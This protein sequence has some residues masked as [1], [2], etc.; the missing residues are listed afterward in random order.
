MT[1][2]MTDAPAAPA[3]SIPT[4]PAT[5]SPQPASRPLLR[6]SLLSVAIVVFG[7][8]LLG[9]VDLHSSPIG[10]VQLS[11][12]AIAIAAVAG[13]LMVFNIE[14]RREVYTFTF[15]EM[16]LLIGLFL[17]APADLV[18]GRL[19]G[20]AAFLVVHEHQQLRKLT[21][22]LASFF[23]E[24][25]VLLVVFQQLGQPRDPDRP[26]TWAAAIVA[27]CAA[28]LLGFI[29]VAKAVRWHGGPL[30]LRSILAIG[31]V[32]APVNTSLAL[33]AV[34]LLDRQPW[35]VLLLAGLA[36]FVL[37]AYRSYTA[38]RQ[39]HESLS[40]LYDFTRM[41]SGAQKPDD[42]L[43]AIL[44]QAKDLLRA[45]RAEIWLA[46]DR[47]GHLGLAVNDD[48]PSFC[49]LPDDVGAR[50]ERWFTAGRGTTVITS[51]SSDLQLRA[52]AR[53][54]GADDCIVAPVTEAGRVVGLFA[55]VNRLGELNG[56]RPEEGPM[57]ATLAN[58]ASVALENGRLIARLRQQSR[59]H[60][61]DSRH[62]SLTR[63]PN[64]ALFNQRLSAEIERYADATTSPGGAV[65][66][67]LMD[68]DGFKEINDT[69]GHQFGD[70]ALIEVAARIRDVLRNDWLVARLGGDEFALLAPGL[71]RRSDLD[72]V[73]RRIRR[74][75]A[76]PIDVDGVRVTTGI[77]IGLA[78]Y[79]DDGVDAATVLQRADVAMYGAKAGLG[80]GVHFYDATSDTN[81]PRRLKLANDLRS[82]IADHQLSLVFQPKVRL[83]D[84]GLLGVEALVRWTHPELGAISPE[85]FIP[86]AER[87]GA[88]VAITE[89]VLDQSMRQ[90]SRWHREGK[91]W[92]V[93]VNLSMRNLLDPELVPLVQRLLRTSDL[94]P[95]FLTLEIT[96]TN[97]MAD[98]SRTIAVLA[99]LADL[100]VRLSIDDFGTGYSSLSYLQRL[101]V[102]EV[103]IDRLFVQAMATE[104]SAET[105][106]RSI[107]DLA[108]NMGLDVV[109]EGIEDR[110][111][112]NRLRT[113]CCDQA[114]GYF[115]AHPMAASDLVVWE[116]SR[117][118]D[119][120]PLVG[121]PSPTPRRTTVERVPSCA[122]RA[123][124]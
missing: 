54:L 97:V 33:V 62:D 79:P 107:L 31:S 14:F 66:V 88:I 13:E 87:S 22:N 48:G 18:I 102:H 46:D 111:T 100:G 71:A 12:W 56:F 55:V 96:E 35:A 110:A 58:H 5:A 42:V 39:R 2:S 64:R 72:T 116:R 103:K 61:H 4:A 117:S 23:G 83:H 32:T 104:S 49:E 124:T 73:A 81:T 60:E 67:A 109:A 99:R 45:E 3:A 92:T 47:G 51:R 105:I 70:L 65:G 44:E 119:V 106:V 25:M 37:V 84:G 120:T 27:V 75:L 40:L 86:L 122:R 95:A 59:Q 43:R 63:L 121:R 29:V 19:V 17:A 112:W 50:I 76:E 101:P 80:D 77:S 82:A 36:T 53:M 7:L 28:D 90:A 30:R 8:G 68:L 108:R 78:L 9:T 16:P 85:E 94:D 41:V 123:A 10:N 26:A 98:T 1:T 6:T 115:V 52:T 38:L 113:L 15:S 74:V 91:R 118:L 24:C 20:A 34:I 69:L 89:F 11:W 114:Q 57:F 21:L 93:S